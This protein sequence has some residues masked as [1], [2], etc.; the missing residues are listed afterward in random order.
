MR[1]NA[2]EIMLHQGTAGI[3][4]T[5]RYKDLSIWL[6]VVLYAWLSLFP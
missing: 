2:S 1:A 4:R 5:H 6:I 3:D